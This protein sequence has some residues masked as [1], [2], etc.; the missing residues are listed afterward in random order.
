MALLFGVF[1]C[2][3]M[4]Q[5]RSRCKKARFPQAHVEYEADV[6]RTTFVFDLKSCWHEK[7]DFGLFGLI[8]RDSFGLG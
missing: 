8:D 5:A 7:A 2:G 4:S 3:P 6:F 1:A